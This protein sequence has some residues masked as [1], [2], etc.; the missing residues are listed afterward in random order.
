MLVDLGPPLGNVYV[1]APE[2]LIINKVH[3]F[4]LGQQTK[5][6][7]DIASI[8]VLFGDELDFLYIHSWIKQLGLSNAW[9]AVHRQVV[10]AIESE[11]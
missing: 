8:M 5:H 4:S 11:E 9:E 2:D 3:Y 10:D 7:H 6:I 1:H